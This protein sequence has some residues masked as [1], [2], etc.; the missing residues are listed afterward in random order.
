MVGKAA[1]IW[2]FL[3]AVV[4]V[5]ALD[6]VSI[7]RTTLRLSEIAAE[8]AGEAEAT[9]RAE[10]F[11]VTKGCEA[12]AVVVAGYEGLKLGKQGCVI[13]EATDRVTITL[14]TTADTF[15]AGRFGPTQP[16]TQI[17]VTEAKGRPSL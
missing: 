8:A 2:L 12:A 17:V 1:V 16:Y 4:A 10:G 6:A 13:D 15:A 14:R 5:G 11:S 9:Y 3:V 7:A